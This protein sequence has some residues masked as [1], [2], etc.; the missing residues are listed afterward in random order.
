MDGGRSLE[1]AR[2]AVAAAVVAARACRTVA[3]QAITLLA[4]LHDTIAA[5][6]SSRQRRRTHTA[7][8]HAY[9]ARASVAQCSV[10]D[11]PH[12]CRW[13]GKGVAGYSGPAHTDATPGGAVAA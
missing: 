13:P 5:L 12:A 11:R 9:L 7:T 6:R 3:A 8:T 1:A 10:E 4:L 2:G